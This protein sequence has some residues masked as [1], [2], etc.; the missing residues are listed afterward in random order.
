MIGRRRQNA[1]EIATC[2]CVELTS[3]A[4]VNNYP[5][6]PGRTVEQM[7]YKSRLIETLLVHSPFVWGSA[8]GMSF[9]L[10][11]IMFPIACHHRSARQNSAFGRIY[12]APAFCL[13]SVELGA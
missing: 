8:L 7:R 6:R 9:S 3:T 13:V 1:F 10:V 11:D 12:Q 5:L 4:K 2:F